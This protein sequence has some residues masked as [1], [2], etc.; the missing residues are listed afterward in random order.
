MPVTYL[1]AGVAGATLFS[2]GALGSLIGDSKSMTIGGWVGPQ[3]ETAPKH[4]QVKPK[5]TRRQRRCI[6]KESFVPK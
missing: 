6:T 4:P 1:R 3:A 5:M 2:F